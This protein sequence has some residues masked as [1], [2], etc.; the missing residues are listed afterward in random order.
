MTERDA[1][2]SVALVG[3]GPGD[4]ALLTLRA[5]ELLS[6]A[7]VVV[8]DRLVG[9]GVRALIPSRARI[10][11]VGKQRGGGTAQAAIHRILLRE[12]RTGRR[13]V[14]LKG[15]DPFVFGRGG[16][17]ALA[18][19]EAG[20][21]VEIVPGISAALAAPAL[22]G[23]PVT[24]RGLAASV[25][26]L[27]AEEAAGPRTDWRA[28]ATADTV[29]LLMGIGGLADAVRA[30]IAAGKDARTPAAIVQH[31]GR[32]EQRVVRTPLERLAAAASR[33]QIASPATIVIGP[34]AVLELPTRT[35]TI[36]PLAGRRLLITRPEEQAETLAERVRA[37]GGHPIVAPAIRIG[38]APAGPIAR[39]MQ[40]LANGEADWVVF[41]SA[42]GVTETMRAVRAM[43]ADA[44]LFAGTSIAVIG[45]AT[46]DRLSEHGLDAD[47]IAAPATVEGLARAFP[48]GAGTAVL[49]RADLADRSLGAAIA[50]KG[51]FP[52][53]ATAYR[54]TDAPRWNRA[55]IAALRE[56]VDAVLLASAG[57]AAATA[58][59]LARAGL[60]P[61]DLPAICIGHVC[62]RGARDAGFP[63]LAT[64]TEPSLD[65]LIDAT[66]RAFRR[67]RRS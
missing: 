35:L 20:I 46:A 54:I 32:P 8:C 9:D 12:A 50:R 65:S 67:R 33:Q 51:W 48:R 31:A 40:V 13:V 2:G 41:T 66:A 18:L 58:R 44:R 5:A 19:R 42:N 14:R 17:E 37:A 29:V 21:D 26:V 49:L 24:H 57:T 10:I 61:A 64:A 1:L 63:V 60:E 62:A 23:I 16:E 52:I 4:A 47:L 25:C 3:A 22:A 59:Q 27:T 38:S 39:S 53:E 43:G 34:T 11:D 7:D 30:L 15:G 56:G 55:T 36:G 6:S 28:A 45:P